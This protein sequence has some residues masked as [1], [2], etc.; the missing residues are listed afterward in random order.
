MLR[1]SG[2][3]WVSLSRKVEDLISVGVRSIYILQIL[4]CGSRAHLHLVES[5]CKRGD[6]VTG[7]MRGSWLCLNEGRTCIIGVKLPPLL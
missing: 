3:S 6:T 5:D 7:V 1:A 4:Y 2:N